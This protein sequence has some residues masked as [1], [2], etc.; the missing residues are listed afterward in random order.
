MSQ[1]VRAGD[2]VAR[3]GG[4]EFAVL[5]EDAD[6]I[7]VASLAERLQASIRRPVRLD[8]RELVT[9][10]SIGIAEAKQSEG[11]REGAAGDLL[12]DADLAM[13]AAKGAGRDCVSA[14]DPE[15]YA[16]ALRESSDRTE[17]EE[18]LAHDEFVLHYQPI[19]DLP[20]GRIVGVEALIRWQH[21]GRGLLGPAAFITRAETTGLIVPIGAWVLRRA[22]EQLARWNEVVPA[23]GPLRMSINLSA[24]QFQYS[25]LVDDVRTVLSQT[26]IDP[27]QV[28]L[29]ITESLLM[30]DT[31]ATIVTLQRLRALGV[32]LA[33]DDFGTGYSSLAYLKRFPIEILKIDK[34]FVDGVADDPEDSMLAG[35][36]VQLGRGLRLQTVAEGIE[37]ERQRAVLQELGCAYGQGYLFSRPI[38]PCQI[39]SM[40]SADYPI[41]AAVATDQ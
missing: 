11:W 39:E 21:P 15:M 24:R 31:D 13:Y 4:D 38:E 37:T 20:S 19:V 12:R 34:S 7:E 25:G 36:I 16:E 26:G 17:L 41:L 3:L 1:E 40:I 8:S 9:T 30:Q 35:A 5:V 14:F 27:R 22:C 6:E 23:A 10:A 32:Q 18:A 29:E 2:T 28:V 33:I